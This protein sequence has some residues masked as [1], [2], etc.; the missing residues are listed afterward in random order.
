[1]KRI[2]ALNARYAAV[3]SLLGYGVEILAVGD[4]PGA[5][6]NSA[7][8]QLVRAASD[9][10][11]DVWDDL[12]GAIKALRWRR[13]TQPQPVLLNPATK[14][15][16]QRVAHEVTRLRGA[17]ADEE[18]LDEVNAAAA[19]VAES[20]SPVGS[21]LLRSIEEVG[22]GSCVVVAANRPTQIA[23][24]GW[25]AE[26]G[27]SVVTVSMLEPAQPRIDLAYA[28][29]P[30]RFYSSALVTAPV[31]S[32]INFVMPAWIADQ[33]VPQSNIARYAEGAVVVTGRS[34]TEGE[35]GDPDL[36]EAEIGDEFLPQP[37]WGTRQS[38]ERA[39]NRDEVEAR[40]VLLSGNHGV[41]LD[42]GQRIRALDPEQPAG[43]RVIYMQV[44]AVRPGVYLLLR[45]GETEHGALYED[46][47]NLL[48]DEAEAVRATQRA[49]KTRLAER[50]S[51]FGYRTVMSQLA[52]M[53]VRTVEQARAWTDPLLI[54]PNSDRD[55]TCLLEWL[56]IPLQPTFAHATKLRKNIYQASANIREELEAAI[57]ATDLSDLEPAGHLS[58]EI[59]TE[60]VRG[61]LA[62]RVLAICPYS[63]IVPRHDTRMLFEDR[64]GRWLE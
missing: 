63:E 22:A 49:W 12:I 38:P 21:V 58:L 42:D 36:N 47:L 29:G 33:T 51:E 34:L 13:I 19:A 10:E 26:H 41:W 18:L 45:E 43:E 25:L 11:P 23:V 52:R 5:R 7:A 16:A 35:V 53:G 62:T 14:N 37:E 48:G 28:I 24:E 8:R 32:E 56:E 1:M 39:P 50:L 40:K 17:V 31:T 30:P 60:G 57:S 27:A 55:F 3:K 54:R 15:A 4:P 20:N 61:I 9:D 6:L 44:E 2:E 59:Q 64:S 46:A